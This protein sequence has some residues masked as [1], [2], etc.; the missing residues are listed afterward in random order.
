MPKEINVIIYLFVTGFYSLKETNLPLQDASRHNANRDQ[1]H[2]Q[3]NRSLLLLED[4]K[5]N[6]N[7]NCHRKKII[8]K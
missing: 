4:K 3:P 5:I 2:I 1:Q 8:N 6:M 7:R